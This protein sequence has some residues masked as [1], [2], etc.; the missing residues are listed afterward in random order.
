MSSTS[1]SRPICVT[2]TQ[3]HSLPSQ[4][5]SAPL[6]PILIGLGLACL[7]LGLAGILLPLLP[8]CPFFIVA[9]ACFAKSS[10]RL[11]GWFLGSRIYVKYVEPVRTRRP[12]TWCRK[13]LLMASVTGLFALSVWAMRGVPIGQV[14]VALVW[15]A[16]MVFFLTR[17]TT[18]PVTKTEDNRTSAL[19]DADHGSRHPW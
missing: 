17:I 16:H 1:H 3:P 5:A 4:L 10:R 6:R 13:A 12:V 15:L 2:P 11:H 19:D 18:M 7:G 8:S 14:V 9:L